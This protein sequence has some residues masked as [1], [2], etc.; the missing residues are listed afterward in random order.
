MALIDAGFA[1]M[2]PIPPNR[3][4]LRRRLPHLC[5]HS[6]DE[7]AKLPGQAWKRKQF[8]SLFAINRRGGPDEL[9]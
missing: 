2:A 7:Q 6:A 8:P 9:G 1:G 5:A 3:F 4:C